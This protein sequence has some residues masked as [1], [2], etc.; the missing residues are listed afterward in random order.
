[1]LI[2]LAL[3]TFATTTFLFPIKGFHKL[4]SNKSRFS[5]DVKQ[6]L[7]AWPSG[8]DVS[9][10][11]PATLHTSMSSGG[12]TESA[13]HLPDV[14]LNRPSSTQSML[15]QTLW[16]P[17]ATCDTST[18]QPTH[19]PTHTHARTRTHQL[20]LPHSSVPWI[21]HHQ[22]V[23]IELMSQLLREPLRQPYTV[24]VMQS[25]PPA[26]VVLTTRCPRC[27]VMNYGSSLSPLFCSVT[28]LRGRSMRFDPCGF[29]ECVHVCTVCVCVRVHV[30]ALPETLPLQPQLMF[31]VPQSMWEAGGKHSVVV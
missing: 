5:L 14:L 25:R 15:H 20:S 28:T 16:R 18:H 7:A 29:E 19:P 24:M 11:Y 8:E 9:S 31:C 27:R 23:G 21:M 12:G 17:V 22:T 10:V 2:T 13:Q 4:E 6:P 1:M 26:Q 3:R 30:F